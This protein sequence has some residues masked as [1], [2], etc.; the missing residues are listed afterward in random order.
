MSMMG[1][2]PSIF[3]CPAC[4]ETIDAS[5]DNCRFCGAAVDKN[6]ALHRAMIL[7]KVNR[8]CSDATYMRTCALALPVF[9]VLR[10]IPFLNMLGAVGFIGLSFVIPVWAIIWWSRFSD[11]ESQ[12]S[13][14]VRS[15]KAVRIAGIVVAIVLFVLVILPGVAAFALGVM[16]GL[17][18][19][20][21]STQ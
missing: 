15:R 7:A 17:Q 2:L 1:T 9:F 18:H 19:A 12:D 6:L 16:R 13:D 8:A 11:L 10:F 4:G 5:A 3:E 14:Y 21:S 20:T